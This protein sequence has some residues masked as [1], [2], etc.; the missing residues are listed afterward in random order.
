MA[1]RRYTE[2]VNTR[3]EVGIVEMLD[4][5][6]ESKWC[7]DQG[8]NRSDL[9]RHLIRIGLKNFQSNQPQQQREFGEAWTTQK[10]N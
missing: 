5:V 4:E 6:L 8:F 3:F 10:N 1:I 9:V 2:S 7:I